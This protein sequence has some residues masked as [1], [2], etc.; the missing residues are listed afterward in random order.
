MDDRTE[1]AVVQADRL[2]AFDE[3]GD[4]DE[5]WRLRGNRSPADAADRSERRMFEQL[6]ARGARGSEGDRENGV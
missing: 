1:R 2:R 6:A 3:G 4:L 5:R